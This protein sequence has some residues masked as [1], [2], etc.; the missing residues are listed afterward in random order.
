MKPISLDVEVVTSMAGLNPDGLMMILPVDAKEASKP[1][2]VAKGLPATI[3]SEFLAIAKKRKFNGKPGASLAY[4]GADGVRKTVLC[5]DLKSSLFELLTLAR[6]NVDS[7]VFDAHVKNLVV[8]LTHIGAKAEEFADA[9]ISA[10]AA[11]LYKFPK[12]KTPKKEKGKADDDDAEDLSLTFVVGKP[13]IS[14]VEKATVRA[15][16]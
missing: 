16:N 7:A 5:I 9:L 8:D 1:D 10:A 12:Y 15:L 4:D 11:K 14:A 13:R 2:A 3:K 6:K